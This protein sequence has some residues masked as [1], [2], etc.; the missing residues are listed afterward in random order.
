MSESLRSHPGLGWI[1][2]LWYLPPYVSAIKELYLS[3]N[4][5]ESFSELDLTQQGGELEYIS[6]QHAL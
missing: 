5:E 2:S 4:A 3:Y 1:V 6:F